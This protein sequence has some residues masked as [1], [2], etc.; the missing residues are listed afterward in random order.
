MIVYIPVWK[1]DEDREVYGAG[2]QIFMTFEE[3]WKVVLNWG[4]CGASD[5]RVIDL[6]KLPIVCPKCRRW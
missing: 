4:Y 1:K 2:T 5:V 3:A 6:D